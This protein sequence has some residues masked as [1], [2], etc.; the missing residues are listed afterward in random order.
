M[1]EIKLSYII[2]C[3]NVEKY[4]GDCLQSIY[5]QDIEESDFE[6][7][8][9]NDCSPDD[10][11]SVISEWQS[12]HENLILINHDVNKRQSAARNTGL[13]AARGKYIW[14][15]DGDDTIKENCLS[16]ILKMMEGNNLDLLLFNPTED[17]TRIYYQKT[18][19]S[20]IDYME[21]WL[22]TGKQSDTMYSTVFRLIKRNIIT[23]NKLFLKEDITMVEDVSYS[24][25]ICCY[26]KRVM[27]IYENFYLVRPNMSSVTRSSITADKLFSA[28]FLNPSELIQVADYTKVH[29][30]FVTNALKEDAVFWLSRLNSLFAKM[31]V[32]QQFKF[33]EYCNEKI[34]LINEITAK[35]DVETKKIYNPSRLYILIM[36]SFVKRTIKK[37]VKK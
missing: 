3:Y 15:V 13:C 16:T 10:T 25:K 12:K 36:S 9:V 14:F 1:S 11:N 21:N 2:P 23:E 33:I 6:V 31:S 32:K 4:I 26:S 28:V 29:S 18:P 5:S 7:I 27:A 30:L 35:V 34:N 8:C 22:K 24:Y 37:I 19:I 17:K 20:G